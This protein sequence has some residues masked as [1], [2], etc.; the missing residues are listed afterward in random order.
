MKQYESF[1]FGRIA[2]NF[3]CTKCTM[4]ELKKALDLKKEL[5]TLRPIDAETEAIIMQKFRLDWNYHSNH[6]EGNTLTYGETKALLL[7]NI[8][9]QGKPLK[10][11][12][13]VTGHNQ[14]IN[15]VIDVVKG[16][17][18]LTESFIRQIHELLLKEPY[19]VDAITLDGKPT[20]KKVHVGKYK[21]T[22]NHVKTVT[23]EIFRFATPEETPAKMTD[24]LN[25]YNEKITEETVNPI[26][27]AAE[28]HYKF[29]RIHPFDDGNG[30][31]ARILM[32]F[33]LMKYGF[34]PTIIKTEDKENY[35][36]ALR[37]ADA[38][39]IEAFIN[40]IAQNLVYSLQL[41]IAGAKGENIEED[42][43]V[44]KEVALLEQRFKHLND[45]IIVRNKEQVEKIINYSGA[46]LFEKIEIKQK[47]LFNRFYE[48]SNF[49]TDFERIENAF[50]EK[51]DLFEISFEF[52]TLKSGILKGDF[53]FVI[54]FEFYEEKYNVSYEQGNEEEMF[55]EVTFVTKQ[56]GVQ[57]TIDEIDEIIE[58]SL[59]RHK[60]SF[61]E[62]IKQKENSK[63]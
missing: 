44:E 46:K 30:R 56:Y 21:K 60:E 12:I 51:Y 13:E 26:L 43:D 33:I 29:I 11:H 52:E 27:L 58:L 61:E 63:K 14:A 9:A 3:V 19:E 4:E 59:K 45:T 8:T 17:Y 53:Y 24:L 49:E 55:D 41:M 37:L 2:S 1:V 25:W 34:P 22:P 16:D 10:D 32:N 36:A 42:D 38:G 39:N 48:K 54:Y 5:D 40:Y 18:P 6:L 28:F 57:L 62:L 47:E 23:G 20:K 31:T 50:G 7:F 35:F 15:W